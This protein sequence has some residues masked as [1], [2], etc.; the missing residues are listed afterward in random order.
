MVVVLCPLGYVSLY[1]EQEA[2]GLSKG[3]KT[4]G[5]QGETPQQAII[6]TP[7]SSPRGG[8]PVLAGGG[9]GAGKFGA[10]GL[11]QL[12]MSVLYDSESKIRFCLLP[13]SQTATGHF[14]FHFL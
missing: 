1:R 5:L 14:R 4:L 12:Q 6:S 10:V 8:S 11:G 3:V 2:R 13:S 7:V 9:Q